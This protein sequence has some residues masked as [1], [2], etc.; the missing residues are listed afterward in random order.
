VL[1]PGPVNI[2]DQISAA[3]KVQGRFS[4]LEANPK[5]AR[6]INGEAKAF[7]RSL[8]NCPDIYSQRD[9]DNPYVVYFNHE[10]LSSKSPIYDYTLRRGTAPFNPTRY[11][12][13]QDIAPIAGLYVNLTWLF[14]TVDHSLER[15]LIEKSRSGVK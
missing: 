13:S 12:P 5:I 10:Y 7:C 6:M 8:S 3:A 11:D 1:W 9:L 15:V 2:S 4:D 14:S